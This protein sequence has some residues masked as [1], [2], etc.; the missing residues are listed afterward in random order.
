MGARL[1]SLN[2]PE[3]RAWWVSFALLFAL[4]A[5]WALADPPTAASDEPAHVI[6]AAAVARGDFFGRP[7]TPAQFEEAP[8]RVGS[9]SDQGGSGRVY[10]SVYKSVRVPEIYDR[11]NWGCYV[12]Q[13]EQTAACLDFTGPR[14]VTDVIS[15]TTRYPPAY[16]IW[17]GLPA[18]LVSAGPRAVY[19]MRLAAVVLASALLASAVASLRRIGGSAFVRLGLLV[20]L[21][22]TAIFFAAS[23]NPSGVEIAAGIGLWVSGAVLVTEARSVDDRGLDA[24]LVAR[25]GIATAVLVLARQL[26]PMWA[27]VILLVLAC[28]AGLQALRV[29]ARSR[30]VWVWGG[31]AGASVIAQLAWIVGVD[32]LDPHNFLGTASHEDGIA[33]TRHAI[34]ESFTDFRQMIGVFG[35][36]DVPAPAL[37]LLIWIA[38]LGGLAALALAFGRRREVVAFV[39][40]GVATAVVPVALY[41]NQ[42]GYAVWQGRYTLPLAVGVPVLAG[43]ALRDSAVRTARGAAVVLV[44]AALAVGHLLAYAQNLRRYTVG[45][46]G[47]VW[48]WTREAWSPPLP[49]LLLLLGFVVATA[50]WVTWLLSPSRERRRAEQHETE[51]APLELV[52]AGAGP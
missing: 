26:G 49:S 36:N 37:T 4:G 30:A 2:T 29:L 35:W 40:V 44:G 41:V 10:K 5:L 28:L 23:V 50:A 38:A 51:A 20:A 9:G 13:L 1:R 32:A 34:G 39:V 48:F 12:L 33:L 17:V 43:L 25:V 19:V 31:V 11:P 24:R 8:R 52:E 46:G 7:I 16:G 47:T 27:A 3:R 22:P 42:S 14:A 15:H 6:H 21:T 45:T 18:R